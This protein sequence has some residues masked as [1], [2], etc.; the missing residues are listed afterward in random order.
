M[1]YCPNDACDKNKGEDRK[2]C[3]QDCRE[4]KTGIILLILFLIVILIFFFYLYF[5]YKK[6][7]K[8]IRK[9]EENKIKPTVD[10]GRIKELE[11]KAGREVKYKAEEEL[12]KSIKKVEKYI[13]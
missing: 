8:E 7:G 1:P 4:N 9:K 2:N 11:R 5:R 6:S 12:E 13:K 3:P 10:I